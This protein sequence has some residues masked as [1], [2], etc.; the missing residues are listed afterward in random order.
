MGTQIC[1]HN[2]FQWQQLKNLFVQKLQQVMEQFNKEEP[3]ER[4]TPCPNVENANFDDMQR[5]ILD[6]MQKFNRWIVALLSNHL[7]YYCCSAALFDSFSSMSFYHD[8][9]PF[10]TKLPFLFFKKVLSNLLV[11]TWKLYIKI[12]MNKER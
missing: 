4:L 11:K 5:R 12:I 10:S 2:R 1:I 6:A 8:W 9:T 3:C 7:H